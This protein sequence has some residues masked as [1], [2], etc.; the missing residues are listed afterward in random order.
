MRTVKIGDF[1]ID[2]HDGPVGVSISG[3]ADSS[4]LFYILMKYAPGPIHAFNCSSFK[5]HN[6]EPEV[7]LR[8]MNWVSSKI[9]RTDINFHVHWK[10]YK[11]YDNALDT[12]LFNNLNLPIL[13]MALTT[14]PPDGELGYFDKTCI[15]GGTREVGVVYPHY[16]DKTSEQTPQAWRNYKGQ[17][18]TPFANIDKK[19]VAALY[20][21]LDVEDLYS[22]TRSCE[23]FSAVGDQ[24]GSCWWC[25]ERIWAFGKLQ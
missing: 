2:I 1:E 8:M 14:P 17:I 25:K 3:G 11:S 10:I 4:I 23:N 13:Y 15:Y 18:Y 7:A 5:T 22:I 19:G 12:D 9:E 21:E 6:Q 24:C 20:K 16:H